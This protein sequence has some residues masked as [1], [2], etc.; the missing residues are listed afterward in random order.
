MSKQ[1][2][3]IDEQG[4]VTLVSFLDKRIRDDRTV[5][6]IAEQ[7]FNLVEGGNRKLLLDFSGV[8]YLSSAALGKL[9]NLHKKLSEAQGTLSMC[10]MVPQVYDVFAIAKL[11]KDFNICAD[12]AAAKAALV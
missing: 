12:E 10:N 7:L 1:R 8:E 2:L 3:R 6:P 9:I 11:D 5:E 4:E